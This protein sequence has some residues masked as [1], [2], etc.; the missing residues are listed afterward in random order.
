VVDHY[1]ILGIHK[2]ASSAEIRAAYKRLA[3]QY[4]PD[5]NPGNLQAE[6]MFKK[7][8]EAY[9]TL[10]DP[11]K[12]AKYDGQSSYVYFEFSDEYLHELNKRRYSQWQRAQQG[13]YRLD[14]EYFRIQ[15]LAFLVFIVIAGFCFSIIHTA[16]YFIEQKHVQR[17]RANSQSLKQVNALFISGQFDDAFNLIQELKLKD[18]MEFRFSFAHDSLV[19]ELRI[20]AEKKYM[21]KDFSSAVAHYLVLKNYENPLRFETLRRI[22]L[23]QYYLGN[24]KE[25]IQAL[26]HLHNQQPD[27]LGLIYQIGMINLEKLDNAEEA[28]HYFNLGKKL[29]KENLSAIYGEAFMLVMNPEDAPDI[30][31]EIFRARAHTNMTLRNYSEVVKDC[32]WAVYLR[33]GQSEPYKLRALANIHVGE[34]AEVCQDLQKA[35][36]FGS[37]EVDLLIKRYCR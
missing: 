14:K 26:K 13:R 23:C 2:E 17:W 5:R 33:P 24:F 30:Y 11:L 16:N 37:G 6:E 4:H 25:S 15:G 28:L 20:I 12:K 35:K 10:S 27:D 34:P 21:E 1:E 3:M 19:T 7:I 32:T 22:S 36:K 29:F 8:N 31:F 18:P 9:H